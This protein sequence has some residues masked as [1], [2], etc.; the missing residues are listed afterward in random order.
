M[1]GGNS[2]LSAT[3]D[4]G[5]GDTWANSGLTTPSNDRLQS[6]I[7]GQNMLSTSLQ[8]RERDAQA[9]AIALISN[10]PQPESLNPQVP[11][12]LARQQQRHHHQR[13]HH[14]EV[15]SQHHHQNRQH[16]LPCHYS[17]GDDSSSVYTMTS[18]S[19]TSDLF[20]P[21]KA[22]HGYTDSEE[23]HHYVNK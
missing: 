1:S 18:Q 21:R 17:S 6:Y 2:V 19:S 22:H 20:I 7:H 11:L 23:Q 3:S 8:P 10:S 4:S 13:G 12:H 9:A 15:E 5:L 16:R 14:H